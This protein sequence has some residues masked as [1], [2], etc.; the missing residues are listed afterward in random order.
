MNVSGWVGG[1]K[2]KGEKGCIR[3]AASY[4][5]R[6]SKP[7]SGS[8]P[9]IS[10]APRSSRCR[11]ETGLALDALIGHRVL[12]QSDYIWSRKSG[13]GIGENGVADRGKGKDGSLQISTPSRLEIAR[14]RRTRQI[15]LVCIPELVPT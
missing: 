12:F 7:P 11:G 4:K 6:H 13:I 9:G 8:R 2:G 1:G 3:T 14:E 5:N 15:P 10:S